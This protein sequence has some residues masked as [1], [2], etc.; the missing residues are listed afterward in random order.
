MLTPCAPPLSPNDGGEGK[1]SFSLVEFRFNA[2]ESPFNDDESRFNASESRFNGD[3]SQFNAS[4][5]PFN[6]DGQDVWAHRGATGTR[7]APK[8]P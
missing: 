8:R 5:S 4:E 7:Q 2:S 3:E 6:D 1:A